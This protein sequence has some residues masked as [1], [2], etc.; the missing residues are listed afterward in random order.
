VPRE[1]GVHGQGPRLKDRPTAS[2]PPTPGS[3]LLVLEVLRARRIRVGAL[4]RLALQPGFYVYVGSA[5]GPGGLAARL[6]HHLRPVRAPH[7]HI[8]YL[9]RYAAVRDLWLAER[10]RCE[11]VWAAALAAM[12]LADMPCPRFGATDCS[13]PAH[14]FRFADRPPLATLRRRLGTAA[15]GHVRLRRRVVV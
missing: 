6:A 15:R 9:R 10:I 14:L 8:D 1:R 5:F 11:H 2:L 4:G 13:C 3:Y 12:P 7:W